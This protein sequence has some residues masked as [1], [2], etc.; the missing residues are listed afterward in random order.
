LDSATLGAA[1]AG[2]VAHLAVGL[3][4]SAAEVDW[5][6][7]ALER[8]WGAAGAASAQRL[9]DD[10]AAAL[11][12][13]LREFAATEPAPL[14]L[15]ASVLPSHVGGFVKLVREID[16]QASVQ[17]HAGNGIVI[18]RFVTFEPG[19]VSRHLIGQLQPAARHGGGSAVVL[20]STLDGLTRQAVWG[21]RDAATAWMDKIKRRFDPKGLLNP[22][23][24][25]Y[26]N[27]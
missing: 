11:W 4:G 10:R 6:F 8:E 12:S 5:M 13:E 18:A 9:M 17:A 26:D 16:P 27:L 2:C 20:S 1:P 25:V 3:D 22:G 7:G 24:F 23:R 15:R 14:V 21:G 19:D